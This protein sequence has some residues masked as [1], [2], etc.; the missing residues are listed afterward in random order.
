MR[1]RIEPPEW[2]A[3]FAW[4]PIVTLGK[5]WVWLEWVERKWTPEAGLSGGDFS[6]YC[7]IE[8]GYT[9]RLPRHE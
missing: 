7:W 9:Y 6:G 4:F 1:K 2:H 5:S 3:W 8:D